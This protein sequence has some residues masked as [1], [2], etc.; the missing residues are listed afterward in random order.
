MELS[1]SPPIGRRILAL[2]FARLPTDRLQRR[3]ASPDDRPLVLSVKSNNARILYAVD[4]KAARLKLKPGMPLASARA[5]VRE[6]AVIEADEPADAKLLAGIADWCD[7]FSPFVAIDGMDGLL[8]DVTGA[9]HLFGGEAA[10]L[11]TVRTSI[12]RQGFTVRAALAGTAA[13]ARAL[14]RYADAA[15]AAPGTEA[16][17]VAFL[18]VAALDLEPADT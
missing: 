15:I 11:Q 14:A 17:A 8:L 2:W 7:R 5:M 13:A 10:M 16:E 9:S 4:L 12:A 18:P 1:A 6:L 3:R